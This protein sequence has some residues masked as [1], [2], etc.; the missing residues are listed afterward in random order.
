MFAIISD[1]VNVRY[2]SLYTTLQTA[3]H[4][5]AQIQMFTQEA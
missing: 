1:I 3:Q 4:R 5:A 2:V